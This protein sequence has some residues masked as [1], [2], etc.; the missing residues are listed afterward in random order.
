MNRVAR[1][2]VL[3]ASQ[4]DPLL[5]ASLVE[6]YQKDDKQNSIA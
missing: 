5:E 2:Q 4:R 6:L 3:R 1:K